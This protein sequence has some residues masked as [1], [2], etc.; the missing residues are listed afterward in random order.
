MKKALLAIY[1]GLLLILAGAPASAE[2]ESADITIKSIDYEKGILTIVVSNNGKGDLNADAE[3]GL[4]IWVNNN[5]EW[6]Y[7]WSSWS[8]Q[9][10]RDSGGSCKIQPQLLYGDNAVRACLSTPPEDSDPKNNCLQKI[11]KS[12]R[13]SECSYDFTASITGPH[14]AYPGDDLQSLVTAK[15]TNNGSTEAE[16][17]SVG[18][19]ISTD[20]FI[21][22]G[23]QLL[24]G[25][26]V[27]VT[28]SGGE[29]VD[30]PI[31]SA[32]TVPTLSPGIYY[33]GVLA[34]DN[35]GFVECDETNNHAFIEFEISGVSTCTLPDLIIDNISGPT[36]ASVGEIV[37]DRVSA[38]IR[39]KGGARAEGASVGYYLSTDDIITTTDILLT[40]GQ[41]GVSINP[42]DWV[43]VPVLTNMAIPPV[44][45]G[46]YYLGILA[47]EYDIIPECDEN[48]NY[49]ITKI[50][51]TDTEESCTLPDL[52]PIL[53]G[54]SSAYAGEVVSGSISAVLYNNGPAGAADVTIGYYL[55]TDDV[56]TTADTL[57]TGGREK[58]SVNGDDMTDVPVTSTLS[59]PEVAPGT[60]YLGI[61][62]D[63]YNKIEECDESNN[64]TVL[65]ITITEAPCGLADLMPE[66]KGPSSA[67]VGE[68]V[69][70]YISAILH[71]NGAVKA[72]NITVGY[73]LSTD[74]VITTAD[75][76]LTGG[77]EK[78]DVDAESQI[79]VPAASDLTIP[80]IAPGKYYL[81]VLADEY[82]KIEECD[83][84]NNYAVIQI[85]VME[86]PNMDEGETSNDDS[87]E[88]SSE[89]MENCDSCGEITN[90]LNILLPVV[91]VSGFKFSV[92]LLRVQD[93]NP[94]T[95]KWTV[96]EVK[97]ASPCAYSK[98][99][100]NA[101]LAENSDIIIPCIDI[102]GST[103]GIYLTN[104]STDDE[105]LWEFSHIIE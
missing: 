23:D 15:V 25:G 32:L 26:K 73:Y 7:S 9:S 61:L 18:F 75:T 76:L 30:V 62:A 82:D 57:L 44:S 55:S 29:T 88:S 98:I 71:N 69:A 11:I 60:Y 65:K 22:A 10:F 63:E 66:L 70:G 105:M 59:I 21:D 13:E 14:S 90:D 102:Y 83:E 36:T 2:T 72:E 6:T 87:N 77:R 38:I 45:P 8:C 34:D 28:V 41:T 93:G 48:D 85:E 86:E 46:V 54:P 17:V 68:P 49:L 80:E 94:F 5:L 4:D 50:T 100:E 91:D 99:T 1:C 37:G 95:M 53:T 78:V 64:Y 58:I 97:L 27:S 74:D 39:N 16:N 31:T 20:P 103:F 92:E 52:Q 42:T 79:N 40:D 96:G 104:I 101:Y 56:I 19:Y 47:D 3:G 24:G 33:L 43:D 89:N 84:T 67:Y 35:D 51:I 12:A 81:G